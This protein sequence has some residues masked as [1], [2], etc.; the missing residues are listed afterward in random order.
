MEN[1]KYST[2][3]KIESYEEVERNK[4]RN[5]QNIMR[6]TMRNSSKRA[7]KVEI[8]FAIDYILMCCGYEVDSSARHSRIAAIHTF[9]PP[10]TLVYQQVLTYKR[11]YCIRH[12][13][14]CRRNDDV[15]ELISQSM[16]NEKMVQGHVAVHFGVHCV[17]KWN[18]TDARTKKKKRKKKRE[19]EKG[20]LACGSRQNVLEE[21]SRAENK[22]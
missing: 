21:C 13:T 17:P 4:Q 8:I 14:S 11:M 16:C 2:N 12:H 6:K 10:Y 7:K 19:E 1:G 20:L 5:K 9:H 3:K 18:E 22:Y 15:N